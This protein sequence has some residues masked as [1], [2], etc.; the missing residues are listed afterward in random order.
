MELTGIALIDEKVNLKPVMQDELKFILS[1]RNALSISISNSVMYQ[2]LSDLKDT[3][4]DKVISRTEELLEAMQRAEDINKKLVERNTEL[5]EARR[6]AELDMSM[7]V[8]VQ[9]SMFPQIPDNDPHWDIAALVKPMSGVSG[10]IYDIYSSDNLLKGLI[11]LDVSGHGISSGLITMI[12]RSVFYRNFFL[13][14]EQNPGRIMEA[15]N[16]ELIREIS[17]SEKYITGILMRLNEEMV[18]YVNAG[19]PDVFIRRKSSGS[20]AQVFDKDG[21]KGGILG[22]SGMNRRYQALRFRVSPGDA[23]VLFSDGLIEAMNAAGRRYGF[24]GVKKSLAECTG[25]TAE[26]ILGCMMT[27]LASFMEQEKAGD[28]MTLVVL[29]KK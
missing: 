5:S 11:L 26:E 19:H 24:S 27:H 3:L 14:R 4:E 25:D 16:D 18:E 15:A 29:V 17:N 22:V 12:A 10:D 6:I 23:L 2:N 21:I 20:V 9:K 1:I 8:N 13:H 7:A 28:D